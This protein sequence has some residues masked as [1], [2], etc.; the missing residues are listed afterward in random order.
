MSDN[1][2]FIL[3]NRNQT[4][5]CSGVRQ[6]LLHHCTVLYIAVQ[7]ITEW[8]TVDYVH[9]GTMLYSGQSVRGASVARPMGSRSR[10]YI[11]GAL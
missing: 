1:Y 11:G 4:I 6:G 10:R 5:L 9:R 2:P 8:H 7:C 3:Y